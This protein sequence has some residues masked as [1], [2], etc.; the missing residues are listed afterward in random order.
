[1]CAHGGTVRRALRWGSR[2]AFARA[3]LDELVGND[4]RLEGGSGAQRH[5]NPRTKD[6]AKDGGEDASK[7]DG[8]DPGA[9]NSEATERSG[10][11]DL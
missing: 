6:G 1:M 4:A 10:R 3:E 11:L 7:A 2:R 8:Q 9:A 5:A